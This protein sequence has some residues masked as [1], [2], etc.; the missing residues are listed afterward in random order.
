M[1]TTHEMSRALSR[2]MR[3]QWATVA[4][5]V[6]GYAG[7][8]LC[9]S[10]LSVCIPLIRDDLLRQGYDP[11]TAKQWLGLVVSFGV[12]AY[13]IGKFFAGGLADFRGGRGT[14]WGA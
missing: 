5:M 2:L 7:D 1:K 11:D 13:A 14:T 4:L 3:R 8:Y 9:R 6:A 10:N 12:L